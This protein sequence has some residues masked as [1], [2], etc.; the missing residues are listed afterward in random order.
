MAVGSRCVK[1]KIADG[2][3][4]AV[5]GRARLGPPVGV[6][7]AVEAEAAVVTAAAEAAALEEVAAASAEAEAS[8]ALGQTPVPCHRL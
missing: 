1:Q 7:S 3:R 4:A 8:P 2:D 5:L 6:A